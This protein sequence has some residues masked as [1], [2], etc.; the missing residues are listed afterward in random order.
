MSEA[1]SDWVKRAIINEY[2]KE[3]RMSKKRLEVWDD[4]ILIDM[5]LLFQAIR[6]ADG[7]WQAV[8]REIRKFLESMQRMG[9][10]E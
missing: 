1:Q 5:D 8:E 4:Q 10:E 9:G 2:L 6:D 7:D 3:T